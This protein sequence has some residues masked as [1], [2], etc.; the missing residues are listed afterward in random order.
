MAGAGRRRV[1]CNC[2]P[3]TC[4]CPPCPR[5]CPRFLECGRGEIRSLGSLRRKA[6][7]WPATSVAHTHADSPTL[8]CTAGR[9]ARAGGGGS[10][11]GAGAGSGQRAG[12]ERRAARVGDTAQGTCARA[13]VGVRS[14]HSACATSSAPSSALP[15]RGA[16]CRVG[17]AG[18]GRRCASPRPVALA[19]GQRRS[20]A[21]LCLPAWYCLSSL[22]CPRRP[23]G[24]PAPRRERAQARCEEA[25]ERASEAEAQL[26]SA[27]ASLADVDRLRVMKARHATRGRARLCLCACERVGTRA[28]RVD[29]SAVSGELNH[30]T[31]A[32]RW[33]RAGRVAHVAV[34][35][36]PPARCLLRPRPD[37][38]ALQAP[39][40]SRPLTHAR[41]PRPRAGRGGAARGGGDGR[42]VAAAT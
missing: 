21:C 13:E 12:G 23:D 1:P 3:C 2:A 20:A 40:D 24:P 7:L 6:P 27:R 33:G 39:A 11:C 8:R 26:E 25:E 22:P 32:A 31:R 42:A 17:A 19:R 35:P 29:Q 38:L 37:I 16:P 18:R 41:P 15:T 14:T 30:L 9:R 10:A 34:Q 4:L 36:R 28:F 5:M